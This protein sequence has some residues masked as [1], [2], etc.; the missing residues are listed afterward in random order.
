MKCA[1]CQ[2]YNIGK[3]GY[4]PLRPIYA[5]LP[6]DHWAVDLAGPLSTTDD[7]NHYILVMIDVCTRFCILKAL[8]NKQSDT[9]A[10]AFVHV[11]ST[12]GYP[13]VLQSDNGTEFKNALIK[14][15]TEH[16]GIEHHL[17]TPYHPHANGVAERWVQSTIQVIR[18]KIEGRHKDWDF[19][20][21][22]TQLE[23]NLKV[24]KRL[25]KLF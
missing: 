24:S 20:L 14:K 25:N 11:F 21:P 9:L 22:S 10:K 6:G 5:Y 23:L 12:F 19:Y 17:I 3:K 8:P 2:R 15:L 7:G 18:K 1:Q 13:R 4:N 16:S